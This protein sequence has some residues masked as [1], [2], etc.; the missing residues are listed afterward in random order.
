VNYNP[1]F[2]T[3]TAPSFKLIASSL[4]T[5]EPTFRTSYFQFS[6]KLIESY[7]LFRHRRVNFLSASQEIPFKKLSWNRLLHH[8]FVPCL[9]ILIIQ[10]FYNIRRAIQT[11]VFLYIFFIPLFF[12]LSLFRYFLVYFRAPKRSLS[13]IAHPVWV[14]FQHNFTAFSL[15]SQYSMT[16]YLISNRYCYIY[17]YIRMNV[18][19]YT[20]PFCQRCLQF[21]V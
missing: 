8:N 5:G 7:L 10:L 2:F 6:W 3:L 21:Y 17:T 13:E 1:H 19:A 12:R 4:S 14:Q 11:G 9:S 20:T 16:V 15:L 18:C